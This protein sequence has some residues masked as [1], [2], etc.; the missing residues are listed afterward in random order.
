MRKAI[1]I[2][3]IEKV[4]KRHTNTRN[5]VFIFSL[6]FDIVFLLYP[7]MIFGFLTVSLEYHKT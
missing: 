5:F 4:I 3:K 1:L 6:L 7:E 2:P